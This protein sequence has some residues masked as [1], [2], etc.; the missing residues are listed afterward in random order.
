MSPPT[1]AIYLKVMPP[2]L[3]HMLT[4]DLV[5]PG[6][7]RILMLISYLLIHT[8]TNILTHMQGKTSGSVLLKGKFLCWLHSL[9][10][11]QGVSHVSSYFYCA[12][13]GFD[14]NL[15]QTFS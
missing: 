7:L 1:P 3:T 4:H 14:S 12:H 6:G 15:G 11:T 2:T 9:V 5:S 8:P 13:C 10:H